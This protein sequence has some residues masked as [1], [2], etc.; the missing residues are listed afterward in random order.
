MSES[1][2]ATTALAIVR[3]QDRTSVLEKSSLT[4]ERRLK[5][6]ETARLVNDNLPPKPGPRGLRGF[7]GPKGDKPRHEWDGTSLRFEN[8]DGSYGE[9][10]DLKGDPGDGSGSTIVGGGGGAVS[11]IE[12]PA[13][14]PQSAAFTYNL[15]GSLSQKVEGDTTTDFTYNPDGS[16]ST[17]DDGTHLF[18]FSYNPDGSLASRIVSPSA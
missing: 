9:F 3:L 14:A 17:K 4:V 1:S 10:V 2:G 18:S 8:P 12:A 7:P 15:D 11:I 13:A 16:L 5:A 6:A